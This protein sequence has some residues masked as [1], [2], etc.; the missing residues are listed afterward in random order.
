MIH[1]LIAYLGRMCISLLV[2]SDILLWASLAQ[3]LILAKQKR[4]II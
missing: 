2:G 1:I 3:K 4:E